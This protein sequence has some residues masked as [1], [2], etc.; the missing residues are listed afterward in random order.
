[1]SAKSVQSYRLE[2]LKHPN[3]ARFYVVQIGFKRKISESQAA[4]LFK[5]TQRRNRTGTSEDIGV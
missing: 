3:Q 5:S 1:M 2:L 4:R